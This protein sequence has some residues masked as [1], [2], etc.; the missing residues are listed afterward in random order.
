MPIARLFLALLVLAAAAPAVAA[1]SGDPCGFARAAS[2]LAPSRA[3]VVMAR[4]IAEY[5]ARHAELSC[6][7]LEALLRDHAPGN[8]A[9][10]EKARTIEGEFETGVLAPIF[11]LYPDLKA[12]DLT[13]DGAPGAQVKLGQP[14]DTQG[15]ARMGFA[16]AQ[17]LRW[18]ADDADRRSVPILNALAS[19]VLDAILDID[20]EIGF[21]AAPAYRSYPQLWKIETAELEK[22][23]P[24]QPRTARSDAAFRESAPP[25]GSVKLTP[26]AAARLRAFADELKRQAHGCHAL[27]IDWSTNT[28][29]R[30]P[31]DEKWHETGPSLGIGSW[32]C[33]QFPP[34]VVRTIDGL[35]VVFNGDKAARFAGKT[36]DYVD[37]RFVF[38]S[39]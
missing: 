2:P 18:V 29:W 15:Q 37:R 36:V 4:E 12:R 14:N 20:S 38:Q 10:T 25:E 1:P 22:R 8:A 11:D 31:D 3:R 7:K 13:A 33:G 26:A 30:G 17:H 21:V 35:R 16:T 9:V 5:V 32:N 39:K 19:K 6:A 24:K 28:R 27:A 23:A 34:D